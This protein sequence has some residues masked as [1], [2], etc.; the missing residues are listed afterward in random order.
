MIFI[1]AWVTNFLFFATFYLSGFQHVQLRRQNPVMNIQFV[2]CVLS[3]AM[4][5]VVALYNRESPWISLAFLI[6][7]VS[8]LGLMIRLHRQLPPLRTFE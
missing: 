8:S 4:I 3:L 5:V 7:A 1:P 2:M 6:I